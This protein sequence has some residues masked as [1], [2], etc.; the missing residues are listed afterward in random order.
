MSNATKNRI[1]IRDWRNLCSF[2]KSETPINPTETKADQRLRIERAKKD[3]RYFVQY[4]LPHLATTETPDFHVKMANKI[5]KNPF[6]KTWL[7]WGRGLAKSVVGDITVPLWL[8][9][10]N[11][12]KFM[13]VVGENQDKADLLLDDLRAIFES[14]QRLIHDFGKQHNQGTWQKGFFVT[15]NG[16]IG[17]A[18]GMGVEPRGL[19]VGGFRPDYIVCDDWETRDTQ[20][21][22]QRQGILADWLTRSVMPTMDGGN[23]RVVLAQN[24]YSPNMI[25]D[26][27]I[28]ENSAW[29]VN[30]I[31]AYC[32]R[33]MRPTWHQKYK[34]DH[35][36]RILEEMGTLAAEAEYNNEPHIEGKVFTDDMIQWGPI[37]QLRHMDA[38]VGTWDVAWSDKKT[39]DYN[40]VRIWGIK[41]G[42][43]YLI[44]C[45]VRQ[46]GVKDAIRFIS[47]FQK[48]LPAN[49]SVPFRFEA[50]FW[51]QEIKTCIT[52]EEKRCGFLLHLVKAPTNKKN[53]FERIMEMHPDYQNGRVTYNH[54]LRNHNSTKTGLGQLKG[55][56]PRYKTKDDAPDADKEAFDYLDK[57][58]SGNTTNYRVQVREKRTF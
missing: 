12:I 34:A 4:Y 33:T 53:K 48:Q 20:K 47:D 40:A 28:A 35:Y 14:N 5:K 23:R 46:C 11:D 58:R 22:P 1:A 44:D 30:R 43:K 13:L 24:K 42:H 9:I 41:N 52:E 51:N 16:F 57:F 38:M 50:Q 29:V 45:F 17:K 6:I 56:E 36:T 19:R 32:T 18:I 2:I 21:N 10:N 25:F 31:N 37:P 7:Q 26:K 49:V 55:I 39:A 15:K 3:Y 8:W 27:I 54:H